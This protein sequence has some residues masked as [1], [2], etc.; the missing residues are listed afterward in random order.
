MKKKTHYLPTDGHIAL[1]YTG[2][3]SE[4]KLNPH[5]SRKVSSVGLELK[6]SPSVQNLRC[7]IELLGRNASVASKNLNLPL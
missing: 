6:E 3:S 2:G 1:V 4:V 5:D 7:E